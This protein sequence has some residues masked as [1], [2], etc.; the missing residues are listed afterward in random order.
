MHESFASAIDTTTYSQLEELM[1]EEGF[2]EVI[3][4]FMSD[5]KQSMENIPRAITNQQPEVVGTICHKLKSSC[6]LVGAFAMGDLCN[7]LEEYRDNH[8][9]AFAHQVFLKLEAEFQRVE[10]QLINEMVIEL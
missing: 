9:H 3:D 6:R 1:G 7:S 4:F 8:D 10:Q 2:R 5:L